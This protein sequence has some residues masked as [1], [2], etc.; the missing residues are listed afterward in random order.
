MKRSSFLLKTAAAAALGAGAA[1]VAVKVFFP[2]PKA[3]A[4]ILDAARRQLGRDVRLGRID[5]GLR[6]LNLRGLEVSERPDFKAGTFLSVESFRLRPSWRALLKRRL[7]VATVAADGLKVRVVKGADGHF[8]YETLASAD[9]PA[10]PAAAAAPASKPGEAPAAEL[11]VRRVLV[12]GGSIEYADALAGT[13][14]TLS[15][16]DLDV[17]DFGQAA[18]FGLSASFRA[19]GKSGAGPVD[20]RV[21]F[22]G[23]I[24]LARGRREK[25]KADVERLSVEQRGL[26][27]TVAGKA[28]GLDAPELAFDAALSGAGR[29][30]L[31]AVG[32]AKLGAAADVDVKLKT[33]GLDLVPFVA[34]M[35]GAGIPAVNV[36]AVDAALAGTFGAGRA[37]VR[38]F[39]ASWS[40]G[41]LEGAGTVRG[42]GG[43]KPAYV[44]R[45]A[46]GL[47]V[48]EIRPGQYPFLR[49]PPKLALPAGRLD[50]T[51]RVEGDDVLLD[52]VTFRGKGAFVRVRGRVDRAL[53]GEPRPDVDVAADL[54]LPA[55]T[56]KDLPFSGAP[57]GLRMPPSHWTAQASYSPRLINVKSLRLRTGSNDVEASGAVTDPSGLAG[58]D[59]AFKCRSFSLEELAQL[60]PQTRDA[61]LSGSG[62]FTLSL[63][64][65]KAK[66]EYA[67]KLQFK[68]L[69]AT[70][71]GLPLSGFTGTAAFDPKRVD[72][73]NLTGR[74]ADGALKM[75]LTVKDYSTAPEVQLEASLDRFD[76]GRYLAAK[77]KLLADRQ[78]APVAKPVPAAKRG[79]AAQTAKAEPGEKARP[80]STR[81]H[82]DIGTLVH[83]NATVTDVKVGWNLRGVAAD[84]RGLNGDA[85][86]SVGGGSIRSVGDMATESKFLKVLI[87]PLL[88]VQKIGRV[89]GIRLFPDFNDIALKRIAGDYVFKDG[90]M[91]LRQSEMDSSVARVSAKG[92]IDLPAELLDLVVTT[93]IANVAPLDVSV[94][95]TFE[96]PKPKVDLAKMLADPAKFLSGPAK[97]LIQGLLKR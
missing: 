53:A 54:A 90:V 95:G 50:G 58:Y 72:V 89:G 60:T 63:K 29:T 9:A 70:L 19:R 56:D 13:S 43:A 15:E 48:P 66:P 33:P 12:S 39:R 86:L 96:H 93:V 31:S 16:V 78:A 51:A 17:S 80:V 40:G 46:F 65:N 2:E 94:T 91:T 83:P 6:G 8:N 87:F 30:L 44:G 73:P 74:I 37:D 84:L 82:L 38:V 61:K 67:G 42:L 52:T 3:R 49:L 28:S 76:L 59:L 71:A 45:L 68:G 64:G 41:K 62:V 27:L 32:T 26:R 21:V 5:V 20:A 14:W 57:A 79:Q 11:D 55:L 22:D 34:L 35:P 81:G 10:G 97:Q 4:W 77:D 7:V 36:P 18:P 69:G 25:F 1:L 47:D 92:T 85:R 75:D 23:S 24:D 88:I